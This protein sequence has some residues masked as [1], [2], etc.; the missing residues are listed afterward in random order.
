MSAADD[1]THLKA[2][3]GDDVEG[4]MPLRRAFTE[5]DPE[6]EKSEDDVEGHRRHFV[7]GD[8]ERAQAGSDDDMEGHATR[9]KF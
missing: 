9:F 8:A 6:V 7:K 1:P 5:D 4:H 2:F 3:E